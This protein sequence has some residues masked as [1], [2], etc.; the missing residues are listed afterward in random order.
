MGPQ[1]SSSLQ[2]S[3]AGTDRDYRL[4]TALGSTSFE[5]RAKLAR[6]RR[7]AQLPERLCFD[8][9]DALACDREALTD[10]LERMLAAVADAEAHL[11]HFLLAW[12][13]RLQHRL[14][15][16]LQVQIDH[17]FGRRDDLAI[18][19]EV[20]QMRVFLLANRRLERDR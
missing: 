10:L 17:R 18:L 12:R 19:D 13:Q 1:Q 16:F 7:M 14:G 3:V 20:A 9:P 8:L 15:L 2:S 4:P 6:P 5:E 11:D